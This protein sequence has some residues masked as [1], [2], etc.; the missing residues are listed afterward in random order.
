MKYKESI[1]YIGF[2]WKIIL[3]FFGL[4]FISNVKAF[5]LIWNLLPLAFP[6]DLVVVVAD[7]VSYFTCVNKPICH[8]VL[9]FRSIWFPSWWE[10]YTMNWGHVHTTI[11]SLSITSLLN[12]IYLVFH[13]GAKIGNYV[14]A[15][16]HARLETFPFI[17]M[18]IT[19]SDD[20]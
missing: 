17:K 9:W 11:N 16:R 8:I 20:V 10:S 12:Y 3:I 15:K 4:S 19:Y 2:Q 5:H 1:L 18:Q 13:L 14:L 6:H 7:V